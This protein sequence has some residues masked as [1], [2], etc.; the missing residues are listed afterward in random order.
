VLGGA[1]AAVEQQGVVG[2][3]EQGCR[4]VHPAGRCAGDVV[5][6]THA[7]RGEAGTRGVV[8]EQAQPE[9]VAGRRPHRALQRRRARQAGSDRYLAVDGDVHAAHVVTVLRQRPEHPGDVGRPPRRTARPDA[10]QIDLDGCAGLG[11][12]HAKEAVIARRARGIRALRQG[13]RQH[14]PVVVV[15]VLADEVDPSGGR[16]D[17]LRRSAEHLEVD[18]GSS[19]HARESR[20]AAPDT[21]SPCPRLPRPLPHARASSP[22]CSRRATPC[23]SATTSAPW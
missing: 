16:P 4:L 17:T 8:G 2:A 20:G 15:G 5:L 18:A 10:R 14:E 3:A 9:Q 22:G 21:M 7:G 19:R 1:G 12:V 6:G 13:D 23:T 11:R